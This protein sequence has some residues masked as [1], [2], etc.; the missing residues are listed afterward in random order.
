MSGGPSARNEF[1]WFGRELVQLVAAEMKPVDDRQDSIVASTVE[2]TA[3]LK[4]IWLGIK[5]SLLSVLCYRVLGFSS[6]LVTL[7]SLKSFQC[8]P[9]G[10]SVKK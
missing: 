5:R 1:E 3:G 2:W 7:A 10:I 9:V 4:K 6:T 8:K